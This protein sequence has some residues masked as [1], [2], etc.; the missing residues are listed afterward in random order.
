MALVSS[1]TDPLSPRDMELLMVLVNQSAISIK[2]AMLHAEIKRK[3]ITDGLTGLFNHKHFQERFDHELRRTLRSKKP[4]SLFL[5]DIDFFKKINDTYGHQAGDEVL[6]HVSGVL[7]GA[8]REIDIPARYGGE[9][10][11]AVLVETDKKSA[12]M[13]AERLREELAASLIRAEGH[14]IRIT[15]SFGVAS[16]PL[17]ADTKDEI[18]G[19]ADKALYHAKQ[20]GRNMVVTGSKAWPGRTGRGI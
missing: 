10:F 14:E 2:N 18:I 7:K 5:M 3:S 12:V 1:N 20:N 4:I 13:T 6:R 9:E 19:K 8:L 11:A 16:Y 17:D 15:A